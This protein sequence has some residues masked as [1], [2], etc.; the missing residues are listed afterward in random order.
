MNLPISGLKIVYRTKFEFPEED[1][2][3]YHNETHPEIASL[4]ELVADFPVERPLVDD[5]G[6]ADVTQNNMALSKSDIEASLVGCIIHKKKSLWFKL[7]L[8]FSLFTTF[9]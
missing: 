2:T 9:L 7:M 5:F 8:G 3:K 1:K 6:N 4:A